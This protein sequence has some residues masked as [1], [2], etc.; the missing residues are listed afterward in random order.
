MSTV[1]YIRI[2]YILFAF[3][4]GVTGEAW[5]DLT[6]SNIFIDG[7]TLDGVDKY[8]IEYG[9]VTVV[10]VDKET[11]TVTITVTPEEGYYVLK[12]DILVQKLVDPGRSDARRRV[13]EI[14]D[15]LDVE[16]PNKTEGPATGTYTFIVP[17][18]YDGALVTVTIS[19]KNPASAVITPKT[20]TYNGTAQELVTLDG[21]TGAK[22]NG[23]VLD[24]D[25]P[26]AGYYTKSDDDYTPCSASGTADGTTTYYKPVVTYSLTEN[27]S[28]SPTIP[29]RTDAGD[30][31]VYY[32]VTGDGN[33]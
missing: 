25:T 8:N 13:P 26:L 1:R 9:S 31:T 5:A 29:T 12:S 23:A 19:G 33:Y 24:V 32:R 15:V 30:Y 18:D 16:G 20:L 17:A 3:L 10:S 6:T 14:A 11:R 27:G 21:V 22:F 4:L 7:G 28:F 2:L